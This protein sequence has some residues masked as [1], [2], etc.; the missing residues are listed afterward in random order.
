MRLIN[1][2]TFVFEEFENPKE[3]KYAIL[4][5]TWEK[6]EEVQYDEF[7]SRKG[8]GKRGWEKINKTCQRALDDG[9]DF[10]WVDTCCID[11]RSSAELTE[12]INSMF[13]WYRG[14]VICYV[15]LADY[16]ITDPNA[17]ISQ[18]RWFTR[19]WTLQ[20]LIAPAQVQF[21]DKSWNLIGIKDALSQQLSQI[22]GIGQEILLASTG[23]N[24]EE[25]LDQLPIA[26]KMSWAATRETTRIEDVAYCLLGIFGVNIP[27]LYGEGKRAFIRL[28]EEIVKNSNDLSLLA[29][30]S[31]KDDDISINVDSYCGVFAQHPRDFKASGNLALLKDVKFTPDFT[32]TNKGLKIQTLLEY[33]LWYDV[34]AM[35]INCHDILSSSKRVGIFLKH[36]GANVFAR[37]RPDI[38]AIEEGSRYQSQ[39]KVFFLSKSISS[40]LAFSLKTLHRYSFRVHNI[41]LP[42]WECVTIEPKALWDG[43]H[44]SFITAGLQDFV[45]YIKY[46]P[47]D[48]SPANLHVL[49]G[50]GYGYG[51]RSN[52]WVTIHYD[53]HYI[54]NLCREVEMGNWGEVAAYANL[55]HNRAIRFERSGQL[56]EI[57]IK[58][59]EE[60]QGGEPVYL[61]AVE[62]SLVFSS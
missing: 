31:S 1:C 24:L 37:A 8:M 29:W 26:R 47:H 15:Y 17:D 18:S 54:R 16:D 9:L 6:G 52:P 12:A 45:G 7:Q 36:Q 61:I 42:H 28:Q 30:V 2:R 23:R 59:A 58:L 50:Y 21:Y 13:P 19:G 55:N 62:S 20:E 43:C 60:I 34:H 10:V 53:P 39:N 11:K 44:R 40:T 51:Y 49:F 57:S 3:V 35:Q 32:M 4:S 22:T 14:S 56:E 5:H 25:L 27:L 33:D 46:A 38:F 41:Q 48:V